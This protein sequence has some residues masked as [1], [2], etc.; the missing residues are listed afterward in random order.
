MC[1]HRA[2]K[3]QAIGACVLD[4]RVNHRFGNLLAGEKSARITK[5]RRKQH[6]GQCRK[7]PG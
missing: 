1:H 2:A 3:M 4:A 7:E 5:A 6:T